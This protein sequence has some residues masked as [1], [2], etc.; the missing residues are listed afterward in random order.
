MH[1][2]SEGTMNGEIRSHNDELILPQDEGGYVVA[3]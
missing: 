2:R 3:Q 1:K